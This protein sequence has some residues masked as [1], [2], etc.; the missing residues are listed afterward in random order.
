[1]QAAEA[2]PLAWHGTTIGR[3]SCGRSAGG[4]CA[5][6]LRAAADVDAAGTLIDSSGSR[7]G[8]RAAAAACL[9]GLPDHLLLDVLACLGG[10]RASLCAAARASRRLAALAGGSAHGGAPN[11]I[12][13][14]VTRMYVPL[15]THAGRPGPANASLLPGR[16]QAHRVSGCA[17]PVAPGTPRSAAARSTTAHRDP[18]KR[19]P[20]RPA[21]HPW[22]WPHFQDDGP[23][24]RRVR[25]ALARALS[26]P[27]QV[28]PAPAPLAPPASVIRR[29]RLQRGTWGVPSRPPPPRGALHP[30]GPPPLPAPRPTAQAFACSL[31]L[32]RSRR[33][34]VSVPTF[35]LRPLLR[36]PDPEGLASAIST[37][38]Q[39]RG[40]GMGGWQ[41]SWAGRQG[42]EAGAPH[43]CLASTISAALLAPGGGTRGGRCAPR[44]PGQRHQR[45]VRA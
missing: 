22:L 6:A 12:T 26:I 16:R 33:F 44:P 38:L 23:V 5:A 35:G 37:A 25:R 3:A 20:T 31:D 29:L 42:V 28:H 11:D 14:P 24:L 30:T 8:G 9:C 41:A 13:L 40:G 45:R 43:A 10:D 32:A 39:V 34:P 18:P 17:A 36:A 27:P 15:V 21:E 2:A 1:M 4:S 19:R 7:G